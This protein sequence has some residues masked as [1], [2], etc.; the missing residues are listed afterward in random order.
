ME[1]PDNGGSFLKQWERG[2]EWNS[3]MMTEKLE[4]L[5]EVRDPRLSSLGGWSG[6]RTS[7]KR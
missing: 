1:G 6:E 5:G 2:D 7:V 4:D 3:A